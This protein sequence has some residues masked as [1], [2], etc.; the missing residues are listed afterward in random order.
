MKRFYQ[1]IV[2]ITGFIISASA[3]ADSPM[4]LREMVEKTIA[5]NP[6]V[7][8]QFH[9][10]QSALAE[11]GIVRGQLFPSAD[12]VSTYRKQ[13]QVIDNFGNTDSPEFQTQLV[14]RQLLFDGFATT[15][16]L[17]RLNHAARVRYYELLN[18]MQEITLEMIQAYIDIQRYEQLTEYAKENYIV[19]KQMFERIEERVTAGV[20][21][22]VDLEQASGR[23]ALAEANL[24]TETT[25]LHDVKAR[26]QRLVG[27]LPPPTMEV[28]DFS[29]LGL[30]PTVTDALAIAYKH[31][32]QLHSSIENIIATQEELNTREALYYPRLDLQARKGLDVSSNGR[33]SSAA[34][35]V[36]ELTLS[37]N[38]F[39]GLSD[40]A[41]ISQINQKLNSTRDLRDNACLEIRQLLVIA[42][43][44]I[45][46]LKEQLIYRDQH[47]LSI[48]KAREAYRKQFDL[49]QRTLL[50][51]LD[52]ENELFQAHRAYAITEKDLNGA[53]ARVY[54]AQGEL[55][56]KL[57]VMRLDLPEIERSEYLDTEAVCKLDTATPIRIDKE[58]LLLDAK[59]LSTVITNITVA[60]AVEN[61]TPVASVSPVV[62]VNNELIAKLTRDWAAAWESKDVDAYLSFYA[63]SFVP[64]KFHTIKAWAAHRSSRIESA[65]PITLILQDIKVDVDGIKARSE[66]LQQYET[67]SFK[68]T[69]VK[70]LNWE[71]I[72]HRWMIVR[73]TSN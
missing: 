28:V 46:R 27:E 3:L 58:Q 50:D 68:D 52:T 60:N 38:L 43:N 62:L 72:N 55:L 6:Q 59:P 44:D 7:Q 15:S 71:F 41:A 33:D 67:P 73:E 24:L 8:T 40:K 39:N 32:P 64:E 25:N 5:S 12:I 23:L 57:G 69:V 61:P 63:D 35:D 47:Q 20:G 37:F 65:G 2:A 16:E 26:F 45:K 53:Y 42:Y 48:E 56:G 51:L 13:E 14:I 29:Q 31:N 54:A 70:V 22:R 19:H 10:Y 66:F 34:A 36:L 11:Q 4:T 21:R 1:S 9:T 30:T 49:G 18:T 17:R